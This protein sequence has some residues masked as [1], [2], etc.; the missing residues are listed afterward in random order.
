M[1]C[2]M[3]CISKL[4]PSFHG[5]ITTIMKN[6]VILPQST[7]STDIRQYAYYPHVLCRI[8]NNRTSSDA[9]VGFRHPLWTAGF[10]CWKMRKWRCVAAVKT[11]E[12]HGTTMGKPW[13]NVGKPW[14]NNENIWENVAKQWEYWI[15]GFKKTDNH[16]WNRDWMWQVT[17]KTGWVLSSW[18]MGD[19]YW[20]FLNLK[21]KVS[22]LWCVD[23]H[24]HS[25]GS[26]M[27]FW[28]GCCRACS[29]PILCF[30]P[31]KLLK[32]QTAS[33]QT[34]NRPSADVHG[35]LKIKFSRLFL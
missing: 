10:R 1:R 22:D 19:I 24:F 16:A 14:E 5:D 29:R 23:L 13:E 17:V 9:Q 3:R 2:I 7:L 28:R 4:S 21:F 25:L 31:G 12:N 6:M 33:P 27:Q 15:Y 8:S 11:W 32:K 34:T 20:L 26:I 30:F 35:F 18:L